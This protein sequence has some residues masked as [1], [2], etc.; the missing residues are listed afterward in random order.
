MLFHLLVSDGSNES[1]GAD[2]ILIFAIV[3]VEWL[4]QVASSQS[5]VHHDV[6]SSLH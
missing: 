4:R 6:L 2:Q 3:T 5:N 1:D